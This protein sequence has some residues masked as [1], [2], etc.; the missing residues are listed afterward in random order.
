MDEILLSQ[1]VLGRLRTHLAEVENEKNRI[2]DQYF[3]EPSRERYDFEDLYES[4]IEKLDAL[5]QNA[6]KTDQYSSE[7]PF[8]TIGSTVEVHDLNNDENIT[9]RIANPS[10]DTIGPGDVSCL[11]P[12]GKSLLLKKP[13]DKV[14]V[15]APGG[16]F[17]Y[18]ILSVK[19]AEEA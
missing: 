16:L 18:R 9:Y 2:F 4:Y 17:R 3:P 19:L 13:G 5:V 15:I 12:V 10:I 14:D 7:I 8:V 11:S 1:I 6:T